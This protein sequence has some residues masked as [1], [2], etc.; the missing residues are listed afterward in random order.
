[1][2]AKRKKSDKAA[3][4]AVLDEGGEGD[5]K[6]GASASKETGKEADATSKKNKYRRDK[7]WDNETIDHWKPVEV[8]KEG[9]PKGGLLVEESSFATLFPQY[10]EQYLKQVWPDVKKVLAEHEIV[11]E[12]NLVEG[13]MT[14][15]TSRKTWDPY[16]IIKARDMI[17]LLA[18]SVPLP[19]AQ[20]ILQ[21]DMTCDIV[22][23]GGMVHSKERFVK[24]RQR[25]VGPNGSTLKAI[26]LLTQ[27]FVLVQGQTVSIM[28]SI[29]GIKQVRRI[30]EDCF[31]NIHPIYHIKELMIRRE[32]EKDPELKN[33]NWDRF[34]PHFKKR[35]IQRKKSKIKKK[36]SKDVFPPQPQP[37]KEDL[38]ME[39]GEY[40]LDEQEREQ[41]QRLAKREA[42]TV[43]SAEK[44]RER[45]KEFEPQAPAKAKRKREEEV[46]ESAKDIAAR[47]RDKATSLPKKTKTSSELLL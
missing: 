35:N 7:P 14:V 19:Q 33:E 28:G 15:K 30:I 37:R 36:K 17:K 18:R 3:R 32:L 41:R 44:K 31:K 29:K 12:L 21:D 22:K 8:S 24:R 4:K 25:L 26:E 34:L 13:S 1:M 5:G 2:K 23:I 47:L 38:L 27:C 45:A 20:K 43:K 42:Q 16:I 10:R 40:F 9:L 11:G 39:S 6:P 46:V